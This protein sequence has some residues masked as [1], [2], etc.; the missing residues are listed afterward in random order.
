MLQMGAGESMQPHKGFSR[1]EV[2]LF[3]TEVRCR[4]E[5]R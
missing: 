2:M 5:L 4:L 1:I 3:T